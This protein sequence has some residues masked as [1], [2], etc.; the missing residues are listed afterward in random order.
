MFSSLRSVII[1]FFFFRSR[2]LTLFTFLRIF[3]SNFPTSWSWY[4][5][6]SSSPDNSYLAVCF[7][8][9]LS[10]PTFNPSPNPCRLSFS[11]S[12]FSGPRQ[13]LLLH[14]LNSRSLL[15]SPPNLRTFNFWLP[16]VIFSPSHLT[17]S[18]CCWPPS[19]FSFLLCLLSFTSF[20]LFFPKVSVIRSSKKTH[21]G[22]TRESQLPVVFG[23]RSFPGLFFVSSCV[24][25]SVRHGFCWLLSRV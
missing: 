20:F 8:I 22:H 7:N 1:L 18:S 19:S 5:S 25:P 2:I 6:D 4:P 23:E 10:H 11:L 14:R 17:T 24:T 9:T 12:F 21:S 13:I 15:N 3:H 16:R